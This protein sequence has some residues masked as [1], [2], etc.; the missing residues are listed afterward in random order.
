[1]CSDNRSDIVNYNVLYSLLLQKSCKL[2]SV[3]LT[4]A[5]AD[6][7]HLIFKIDRAS[8]YVIEKLSDRTLSSSHFGKGFQQQR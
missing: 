7:Y 5:V 8:D 6:E 1:M 4:V 3:V 2:D